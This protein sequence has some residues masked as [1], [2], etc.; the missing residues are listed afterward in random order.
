MVYPLY[1]AG[2]SLADVQAFW[3]SHPFDLQL[4]NDEGNCDLCFLKGAGKIRRILSGR[5][6]LAEWWVRMETVFP[7]RQSGTERFRSD[8]P[9]YRIQLEMAQQ[10][11][12]FDGVEKPDELS[13]ACHVLTDLKERSMGDLFAAI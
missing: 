4:D 10:A 11:T 7:V 6:D 2:A 5:P 13:E 8:R 12:L 3:K 1:H 9:S